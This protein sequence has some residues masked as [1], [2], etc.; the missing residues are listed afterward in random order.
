MP[1]IDEGSWVTASYVED[2][3]DIKDG[4][5]YIVVSKNEGIMFKRVYNRLEKEQKITLVS[6][7]SFYPPFDLQ[8]EDIDEV[9]KFETWNAFDF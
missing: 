4:E 6:T 3:N 8:A 5:A 2:W 9:W 7:N 1:P